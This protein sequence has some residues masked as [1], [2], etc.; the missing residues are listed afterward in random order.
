[1][2]RDAR[3]RGWIIQA[4]ILLTILL[5]AALLVSTTLG[6]LR[7][8]GIPIGFD[9]LS[10]PS[11]IIISESILVHDPGESHY[12]SIVVGIANT[13]FVSLL[14]ILFSSVLGLIVGLTRLSSNPLAAGASRVW[15]ELAR[16]FPPIVILIFLYS[17]WW[18]VFPAVESAWVVTPGVYLS[19]RGMNLPSLS[20]GLVPVGVTMMFAGV[21]LWVLR[22]RAVRTIGLSAG[23]WTITALGLIAAGAWIADPQFSVERPTFGGSN[24]SGG[25]E[26]SPELSTILIGLT[27]YTTGFVAEIVRGGVLAIGKG[28]WEA[29]RSLGLRRGKILRFIIIPQALRV[30]VPPLNSQYINVVKNSTLAIAVGYPDFLSVMNTMISKSSHSIEGV[31]IIVTVYL[32]INLALSSV[33]NWY[34]RRIGLAER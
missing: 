24:F 5:V 33:A 28:Q 2:F 1:M 23:A 10:T 9:F 31:L 15:V 34:N 16:N 6:N 8:R 25:I 27:L 7:T 21:L 13:L 11:N 19:M 22:A 20:L 14:V 17:L 3:R 18:K 30:I 4:A 32:C 29:G 26:L 12:R